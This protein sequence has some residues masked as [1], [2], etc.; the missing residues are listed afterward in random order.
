MALLT[1]SGRIALA[2]SLKNQPLHLAWGSGSPS[3]ETTSSLS[4]SQN[5]FILPNAP[6]KDVIFTDETGQD[7]T[8]QYV[9]GYEIELP[10]SVRLNYNL[11]P[12]LSKIESEPHTFKPDEQGQ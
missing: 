3:W 4:F 8:Q 5:S 10:H 11:D 6:V 7:V 1:R 9:D 2:A 12:D